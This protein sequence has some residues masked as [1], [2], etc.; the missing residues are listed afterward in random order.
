MSAEDR[1][2]KGRGP[3]H[4]THHDDCGCLTARYEAR[5]ATLEAACRKLEWDA[6]EAM[7]L[8]LDGEGRVATLE[9]ERARLVES[10]AY[11]KGLWE[12]FAEDSLKAQAHANAL[13]DALERI[14]KAHEDAAY[15]SEAQRVAVF[16]ATAGWARAALLATPAQSLAAHDAE[17]IARYVEGNNK[18]EVKP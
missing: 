17:V 5:I 8:V 13:R 10:V 9:G 16:N 18:Q 7:A 2:P 11:W 3:Q 12:R 14:A 1:S 4:T 6:A 15:D